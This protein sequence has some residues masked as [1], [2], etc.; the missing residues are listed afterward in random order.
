MSN[1]NCR[2]VFM[3]TPDFAVTI[4]KKLVESSYN[5]VAVV[6]VPDKPAGRG[7]KLQQ[8][9]VKQY[10]L[11]QNLPVL[12][13]VKLKDEVFISE[14][15]SFKAD[16]QVVVAFRMLPEVVWAMPAKGTFNL[17]ASLLPQYRGAAPINWAVINGE[18][19][20]G[21]TTF[22]I[23]KEIDTGKILMQK[24]VPIAN[25]DTAG[26][27][28]DNLMTVG[29]ELVC[30]TIDKIQSE[31]I[32]AIDQSV[33]FSSEAE[34]KPAPKIQ[35]EDCK[36]DWKNTNEQIYNHIRGFAPYPAA[37]TILCDESGNETNVKVFFANKA[38]SDVCLPGT[39]DTDGKSFVKVQCMHGALL[40][41]DIQLAG[42]K[43]ME[44][45]SFLAGSKINN[46]WRFI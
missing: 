41:T 28:H 46:K 1:S 21:V 26:H 14:L 20:S 29:A 9:A 8:S 38:D 31:E 30:E 39:V 11:T 42:K 37:W 25:T 33:F 17:H 19:E 7:H 10:A 40:L 4:L 6:T 43:R 12:Q 22:L 32:D 16:L 34:L 24:K 15:K 35:K 44:I 13:P 3:G 2:I 18:T 27:L 5:V 45:K 23:D 36:I